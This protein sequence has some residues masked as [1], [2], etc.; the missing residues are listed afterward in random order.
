[1]LRQAQTISL[2]MDGA[3][4]YGYTHSIITPECRKCA[5]VTGFADASFKDVGGFV[6]E[7]QGACVVPL[8]AGCAMGRLN[9]T[10]ALLLRP[11]ADFL[12]SSIWVLTGAQ[13]IYIAS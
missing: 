13:Q 5:P 10:W 1:M 9:L 12:Y 11:S 2:T 4:F 3:A 6:D 7:F 8:H